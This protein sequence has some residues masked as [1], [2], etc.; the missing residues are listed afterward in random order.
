MKLGM[1]AIPV[2]YGSEAVGIGDLVSLQS[3]FVD[4]SPIQLAVP[5]AGPADQQ[6]LKFTAVFDFALDKSVLLQLI[7]RRC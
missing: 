4:E 1:R 6:V 7:F 5:V 2:E 3:Q